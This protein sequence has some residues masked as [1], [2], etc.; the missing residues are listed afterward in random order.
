MIFF[1][2]KEEIW[3][4]D[5]TM[6]HFNNNVKKTIDKKGANVIRILCEKNTLRRRRALRKV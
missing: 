3:N 2:K 1:L 4:S 6:I 5:E